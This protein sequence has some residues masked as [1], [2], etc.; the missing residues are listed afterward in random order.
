MYLSLFIYLY[1]IDLTSSTN[2]MTDHQRLLYRQLA[3][4]SR[5]VVCVPR[6]TFFDECDKV[7]LRKV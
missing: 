5:E 7:S 3:Y 6:G 2:D 4:N 1:A